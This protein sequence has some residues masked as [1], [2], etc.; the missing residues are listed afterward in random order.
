[1]KRLLSIVLLIVVI[2]AGFWLYFEKAHKE[3]SGEAEATGPVPV[4]KHSQ[5][6]NQQID[7]AINAYMQLKDAFVE[8]DSLRAKELAASFNNAVAKIDMA[9]LEKDDEAIK[10]SAQQIKDQI[11]QFAS[12]ISSREDI[13]SMRRDFKDISENMYP[14]LKTIG[15]EGQ[16]LYWDNCPMAFG[17]EQANWLSL[18]SNIVNPY[19]GKK[20]PVYKGGMLNCGE[21]VDSLYLK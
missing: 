16:K 9:G 13:Q 2:V 5:A 10:L 3:V 20:H 1:M 4:M 17:D 21:V 12:N 6:F 8:A 7:D 19:L 14:L 18:T 15:Y 11:Q